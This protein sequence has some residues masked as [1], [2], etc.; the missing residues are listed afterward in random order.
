MVNTAVRRPIWRFPHSPQGP[1]T[2]RSRAFCHS[3]LQYPYY[4]V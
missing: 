1:W 4:S 3:V 2:A